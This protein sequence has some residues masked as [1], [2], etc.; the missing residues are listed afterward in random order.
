[1]SVERRATGTGQ[2]CERARAWVSRRLDGDLSEFEGALLDAHVASCAACS[3]FERDLRAFTLRLRE[4]TME[5]VSR[6]FVL[7][8]RSRA[9]RSPL[10][11]AT[12]AAVIVGALGT[13]IAMGLE[14]TSSIGP[15]QRELS[16]EAGNRDIAQLRVLRTAQ[17]KSRQV[18]PAQRGVVATGSDKLQP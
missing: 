8:R 2:A 13:A 14:E 7:P 18:E 4:A 1:M 6:P 5:P 9:S 16:S 3:A 17:L 10:R 12:A 11:F 15:S